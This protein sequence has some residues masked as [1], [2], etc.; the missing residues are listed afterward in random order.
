[1]GLSRPGLWQ[2]ERDP[3]QEPAT[4]LAKDDP[5]THPPTIHQSQFPYQ[6][7]TSYLS[8][9][10]YHLP[11]TK[12]THTN[13]SKQQLL[14]TLSTLRMTHPLMGAHKPTKQSRL[15]GSISTCSHSDT[16]T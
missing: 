16:L 6:G 11:I 4:H 9:S 10:T 2:D 12:S 3:K 15:R 8:L 14:Q 13:P 1:M 7:Q 5:L